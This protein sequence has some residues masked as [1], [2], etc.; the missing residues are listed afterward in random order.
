M[1]VPVVSNSTPG[2]LYVVATPI[3][4]LDD[5]SVRALKVLRE[6]ALIAAEDTRHSAR[7]MQHFGIS[8]PLAA[9]HEH[10]ERDEGSRFITRLLAGDDVALISDAGTPLISDPG[11]HLVRQ[12]RA[13]GVPVVPVP[14][15]C[16]LI[17]ALSAAG[18]PSDRFIFEGF[19]PAKAAGR[20]AKLERVKEEPR[21][22]IYYEAPHRI[23]ECLQDMEQ[24]FGADRQALLAR[25]ITKTFETLKGL[26]LGELRAFV[27]A[28][29]NQQRGECVV[30]IAGWTPPE[31]EDVIGEEARR[32]L[33][34]LLAEMPLKRAATLAAEIT[35]VRKNLLYQVALEK[36]KE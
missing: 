34:L 16:A 7:L 14:G 35:G 13:V 24:V 25:E 2:S 17:A 6:V 5:M 19:L 10:N 26:P 36:Q 8:T 21:T 1:T 12:A 20:K 3:G 9:C 31:D 28:D 30:L 32:I 29:S 15:A 4:N 23:L 22:L 27:E 18:L 11:Y 33:D